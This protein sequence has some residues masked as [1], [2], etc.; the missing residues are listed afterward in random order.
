MATTN[1]VQGWLCLLMT[2][3]SSFHWSNQASDVSDPKR[4][5]ALVLSSFVFWTGRD[6]GVFP[7][8]RERVRELA[9]LIVEFGL[10]GCRRGGRQN[11]ERAQDA[12]Q[13]AR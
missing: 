8:A 6:G 1:H 12:S 7:C 13:Q 10:C 2:E 3:D 11:Q 5:G 4:P 9:I